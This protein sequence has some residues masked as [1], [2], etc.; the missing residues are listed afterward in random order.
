MRESER[1]AEEER[2]EILNV[3]SRTNERIRQKKEK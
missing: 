3:F 2:L 1:D